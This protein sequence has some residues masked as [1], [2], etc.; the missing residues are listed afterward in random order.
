MQSLKDRPH[1]TEA[2]KL[3]TI[4]V[5]AMAGQVI[6]LMLSIGSQISGRVNKWRNKLIY[7]ASVTGN[8]NK[9]NY[10]AEHLTQIGIT[11]NNGNLKTRTCPVIFFTN[12][13]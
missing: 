2:E 1:L 9:Y 13:I 4:K 6:I 3:E 12:S 10:S 5:F 7:W 8:K 11:R